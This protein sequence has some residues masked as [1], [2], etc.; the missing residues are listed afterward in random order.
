MT[1]RPDKGVYT[2]QTKLFS[3]VSQ[4]TSH[5]PVSQPHATITS[6]KINLSSFSFLYL[7][8]PCQCIREFCVY[9]KYSFIVLFRLIRLELGRETLVADHNY[10]FSPVAHLVQIISFYCHPRKF[11]RYNILSVIH[12]YNKN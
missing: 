8:H 7:V 1:D 6:M 10:N 9:T 2:F 11:T 12:K 5:T 3:K 4:C